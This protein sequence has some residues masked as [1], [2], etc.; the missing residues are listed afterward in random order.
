MKKSVLFEAI[1]S[2]LLIIFIFTMY[3]MVTSGSPS[4]TE[5]WS[6]PGIIASPD[7]TVYGNVFSCDNGMLYTVDDK[8]IHALGGNGG[9]AWNYTIPDVFLPVWNNGKWTGISAATD[10]KNNLYMIVSSGDSFSEN[11]RIL[12]LSP[13]GGLLWN[14]TVSDYMVGYH[15][16]YIV[17]CIKANGNRLYLFTGQEAYILDQNGN[18]VKWIDNVYRQP[19]VDENGVLYLIRGNIQNTAVEASAP[20]GTMLWSHDLSEYG[21]T[22]EFDVARTIARNLYDTSSSTVNQP[23]YNNHTL[24]LLFQHSVLS[25]ST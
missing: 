13:A 16:P 18:E 17:P 19:S 4:S 6:V 9:I 11:Y 8:S 24:Y 23:S 21:I 20:D 7:N 3:L 22:D 15:N 14:R 1:L 2:I 5:M 12:A 10:E 25:L